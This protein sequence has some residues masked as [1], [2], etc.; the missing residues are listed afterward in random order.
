EAPPA[1]PLQRNDGAVPVRRN[2]RTIVRRRRRGFAQNRDRAGLEIDP[3]EI[4]Q[5]VL[6]SNA[7]RGSPLGQRISIANRRAARDATQPAVTIVPHVQVAAVG[8]IA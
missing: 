1:I 4:A 5:S 3:Y 7:N 6:A 8:A 2:A